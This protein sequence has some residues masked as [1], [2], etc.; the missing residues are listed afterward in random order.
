MPGSCHP[1]VGDDRLC[2]SKGDFVHL[3]PVESS[4]RFM[5]QFYLGKYLT[6]KTNTNGIHCI[7]A[8]FLDKRNH[9]VAANKYCIIVCAN[10]QTRSAAS[11]LTNLPEEGT[12]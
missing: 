12:T 2:A 1:W 5:E 3:L 9:R 8:Y 11:R 10:L 4:L 7:T 6:L